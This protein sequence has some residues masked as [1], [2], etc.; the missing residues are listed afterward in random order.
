MLGS[1]GH[2]SAIGLGIARFANKDKKVVVLDGDGGCLM[3][4]GSMASVTED[5]RHRLIHIVLDN[6]SYAS[7]GGQ[8]TLSS[9]VNLCQ[10]AKGCG[11]KN[12]YRINNEPNLQ[13]IFP[14][15][16]KKGGPTFVHILISNCEGKERPRI[17]QTYT[18][19]DIKDRFIDVIRRK[20]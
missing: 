9:S 8:P 12:I 14:S 20:Q 2:A 19:E 11:Y 15:I 7:T 1:M 17:S 5:R 13:R 4:L 3:H 18:C 6:A 16:L 10:I